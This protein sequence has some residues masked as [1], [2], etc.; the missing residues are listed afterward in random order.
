MCL[1]KAYLNISG[2][3]MLVMAEVTLVK[4]GH[5]SI[6]LQSLFG[7]QK[8]VTALIKEVNFITNDILMEQPASTV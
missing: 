4:I 7:E 5:G 8:T 2:E 6:T 1:S 3:C